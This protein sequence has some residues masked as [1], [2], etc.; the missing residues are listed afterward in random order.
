MAFEFLAYNVNL[1]VFPAY[2]AFSKF[3]LKVYVFAPCRENVLQADL[4]PNVVRVVMTHKAEIGIYRSPE[5][6]FALITTPAFERQTDAMLPPGFP[7]R[8]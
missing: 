7:R 4:S 2:D 1:V 3:F 8:Q 6:P 5:F